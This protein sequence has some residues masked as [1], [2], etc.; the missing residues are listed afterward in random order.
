MI[1]GQNA[2]ILSEDEAEVLLLA[3]ELPLN[4]IVSRDVLR[5]LQLCSL[6]GGGLSAFDVATA[7]RDEIKRR[8]D[9]D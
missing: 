6:N 4:K 3:L 8:R 5:R 9:E 2:I 1:S 7:I